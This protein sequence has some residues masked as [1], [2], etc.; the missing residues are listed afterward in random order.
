[1][2]FPLF[3]RFKL[4]WTCVLPC[5]SFLVTPL[6]FTFKQLLSELSKSE[7]RE[8]TNR[9]IQKW[10]EPLIFG[11]KSRNLRNK[12]GEQD[13]IF[14]SLNPVVGALQ[15]HKSLIQKKRIVQWMYQ[16]NLAIFLFQTM[17]NYHQS[18]LQRLYLSSTFI[19]ICSVFH[20]KGWEMRLHTSD[21]SLLGSTQK[22]GAIKKIS[23][24]PLL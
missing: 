11:Y 6:L 5:S 2:A 12:K 17:G 1:M 13:A 16:P 14:T 22:W 15:F 10:N 9:T 24:Q 8:S 21:A 3:T 20:T 18:H 23:I 7:D 4:I 19:D